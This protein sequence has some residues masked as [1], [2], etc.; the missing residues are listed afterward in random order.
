MKKVWWLCLAI[1]LAYTGAGIAPL[2]RY[3][4]AGRV[5]AFA[6]W[7]F[8][9]IVLLCPLLIPSVN[10]GLPAA[11]A[12]TSGDIIFKMVEYFRQWGHVKRSIVLRVFSP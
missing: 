9:R 10:V 6:G 12:F 7:C 5:G 2:L 8:V 11:S 3:R 1:L 4:L